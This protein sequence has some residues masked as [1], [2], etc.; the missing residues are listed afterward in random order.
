MNTYL[1]S[2]VA[3]VKRFPREHVNC[4][5]W[6]CFDSCKHLE[7]SLNLYSVYSAVKMV[8]Y[9]FRAASH[10]VSSTS[11]HVPQ[12]DHWFDSHGHLDMQAHSVTASLRIGC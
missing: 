7:H 11:E 1:M 4:L 12:H 3:L 5:L 6:C 9:S 2:S 8:V 10:A